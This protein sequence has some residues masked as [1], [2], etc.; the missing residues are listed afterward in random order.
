MK[1]GLP[2]AQRRFRFQVRYGAGEE[3]SL[4]GRPGQ[5]SA[6]AVHPQLVEWVNRILKLRDVGR[7]YVIAVEFCLAPIT[8][9][10][11][12]A[13]D[14]FFALVCGVG[15][16]KLDGARILGG[17]LERLQEPIRPAAQL[18]V[19]GSG[20]FAAVVLFHHAD[21]IARVRDRGYGAV[22]PLMIVPCDQARE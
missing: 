18:D 21:H 9:G 10:S 4:V 16:R 19:D 2:L 8:N 6:L 15:D 13:E 20:K 17:Q 3:V 22:S 5:G 1:V 7:P 14:W 11:A 12:G